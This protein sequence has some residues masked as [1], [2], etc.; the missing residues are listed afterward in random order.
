MTAGSGRA[1]APAQIA[2][3]GG[4]SGAA[5][6]RSADGAGAPR[7]AADQRLASSLLTSARSAN[8]FEETVQRLL[9]SIRLGLVAP[10]ARLPAERELAAML[11]VSRDKLRQALGALAQAGW[12]VARRGRSGGNFVAQVLPAPAPGDAAGRAGAATLADTLTL[13]A[14]L[15]VG[16]AHQVAGCALSAGE[17]ERIRS[18]CAACRSASAQHYRIADTRLHL[19]FAELTQARSLIPLLADVRLRINELLD[20]FP[21]LAPN[22]AHSNAQHAALVSAILERRPQAA[23]AAMAE[24]LAG[25]GALLRGFYG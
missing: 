6:A 20:G 18:A 21:L 17:R 4:R 3:P 9:Q 23:A 13:R 8:A 15:E 12:V 1:R 10:G 5:G 11:A 7:G 24:H 19:L 22:I 14:V 2:R 16:I 25:T